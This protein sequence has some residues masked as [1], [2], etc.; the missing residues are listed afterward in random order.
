MRQ[1][2]MHAIINNAK[3]T[4]KEPTKTNEMKAKKEEKCNGSRQ[5]SYISVATLKTSN[6][7]VIFCS[8][9]ILCMNKFH[10]MAK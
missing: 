8:Y 5:I 2:E 10:L 7:I 6:R 9:G 1:R 4:W 3:L